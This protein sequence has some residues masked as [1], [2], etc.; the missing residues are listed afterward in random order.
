MESF[1][2]CLG[3]ALLDFMDMN[4]YNHNVYIHEGENCLFPR[5]SKT[6]DSTAKQEHNLTEV[7]R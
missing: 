5:T 6:N 7:N 4:L 3:S 1:I 2:V